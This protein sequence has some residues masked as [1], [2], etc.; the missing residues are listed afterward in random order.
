MLTHRKP[1][2]QELQREYFRA[3]YALQK[4]GELV[5]ET[6]GLSTVDAPAGRDE[7]EPDFKPSAVIR[8]WVLSRE[9]TVG[10]VH[11]TLPGIDGTVS[12]ELACIR[13]GR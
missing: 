13:R 11:M 12:R 10:A 9:G 1:A 7:L 4:A 6:D 8:E 3:K 2:Q 5:S